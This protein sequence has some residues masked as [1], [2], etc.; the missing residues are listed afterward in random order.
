[1]LSCVGFIQDVK[2]EILAANLGIANTI[3]ARRFTCKKFVKV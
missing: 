1:M 2:L 3:I